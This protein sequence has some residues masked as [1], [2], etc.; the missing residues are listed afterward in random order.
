LAL[1]KERPLS[2]VPPHVREREAAKALAL[3]GERAN[4]LEAF[5]KERASAL[6]DDHLRVRAAAYRDEKADTRE[7]SAQVEALPRPDVIGVFILL[8]KVG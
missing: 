6:L 3:L 1:L 7:R 8:P 5:A 2:D 4:E